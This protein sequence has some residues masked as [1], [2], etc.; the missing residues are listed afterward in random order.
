MGAGLDELLGLAVC[1]D[2]KTRFDRVEE[3]S[4]EGSGAGTAAGRK[5]ECG[6]I[7]AYSGPCVPANPLTRL[8]DPTHS[9]DI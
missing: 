6:A 3:G 5:Q 7:L 1:E 4:A 2:S 9:P 8:P